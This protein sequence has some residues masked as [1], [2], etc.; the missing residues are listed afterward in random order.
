MSTLTERLSLTTLYE[1]CPYL[2]A[3]PVPITL[4]VSSPKQIMYEF[5]YIYFCLPALEHKL[6]EDR[7][8]AL[9]IVVFEYLEQCLK[10]CIH[11]IKIC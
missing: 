6:H 7:G 9:S 1:S 10:L 8:Y 2:S 4:L 11:T 3:C 5:V